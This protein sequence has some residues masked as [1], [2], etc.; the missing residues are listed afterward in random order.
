M[1][2]TLVHKLLVV[3]FFI[4][5][6]SN[7]VWSKLIVQQHL[8]LYLFRLLHLSGAAPA[9][10][11]VSSDSSV[12]S[13]APSAFSAFD[14][15]TSVSTPV[16]IVATPPRR[17]YVPNQRRAPSIRRASARNTSRD[18]L[19]RNKNSVPGEVDKQLAKFILDPVSDLSRPSKHF[20]KHECCFGEY[21]SPE[22]VKVRN[23][24]Y[25]LR[26]MQP[27]KFM[28]FCRAH[29]LVGTQAGAD[30]EVSV[31][32]A[33]D[34][35]VQ[36]Q[37]APQVQTAQR[38]QLTPRVQS[39]PPVQQ[40]QQQQPR[41]R[42]TEQHNSQQQSFRPFRQTMSAGNTNEL[43]PVKGS[44]NLNMNR[45]EQSDMSRILSIKAERVVANGFAFMALVRDH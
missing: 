29:G 34:G 10:V 24:Y 30:A 11:S 38:V 28:D 36:Q 41:L 19:H 43:L 23:R 7:K 22:R 21:N 26:R 15:A 42:N 32:A 14:I 35:P 31:E 13:F 27:S 44:L 6:E 37:L 3:A 12:D 16:S 2:A 39:T 18:P 9:F 45:P 5:I 20:N 40:Q 1:H 17:S 4:E 8:L 33:S 25:E